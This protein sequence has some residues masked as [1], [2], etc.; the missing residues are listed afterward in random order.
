[1]HQYTYT[2]AECGSHRKHGQGRSKRCDEKR[3]G[4]CFSF[5][6]IGTGVLFLLSHLDMLGGYTVSQFWPLLLVLP[7]ISGLIR[8]CSRSGRI[9]SAL[10]FVFASMAL[11]NSLRL[12][13]VPWDVI[14]PVT[15]VVLGASTLAWVA[16]SPRKK[17][18]F[19]IP[20]AVASDSELL[21]TRIVCG[22]NE[23]DFGSAEFKGGV[24]DI[25]MGG[26]ELDLRAAQMASASAEL[27]V[28]IKLGGVKLR[29]PQNWK[30]TIDGETFM[31]QIGDDT[32]NRDVEITNELK[33]TALVRQGA[34]EIE[35]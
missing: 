17:T 27:F 31:G 15:V 9:F 4:F 10:V 2:Y 11:V 14:W 3:G 18:R 6:L 13:V 1:M 5:L 23:E 7:A 29:V 25:F 34:L 28:K 26:Y 32:S 8:S 22:G 20:D 12:M 35:N 24:V 33:I 30:V 21:Q 16:L 19:A